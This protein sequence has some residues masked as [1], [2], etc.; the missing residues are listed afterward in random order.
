MS[1]DASITLSRN[2]KAGGLVAASVLLSSFFPAVVAFS[3][4]ESPFLFAFVWQIGLVLGQVVFLAGSYSDLLRSR[5]AW[6]R[7]SQHIPSIAMVVWIASQ[8]HI[9]LFVWSASVVDV[10]I[11]TVLY[12]TWPLGMA[13][14]TARL[15]RSESRYQRIGPL[16]AL[17]F[18]VAVAGVGLVALSHAGDVDLTRVVQ[19][20]ADAPLALAGGVGL[21]L[22]A[23][24]VNSLGSFGFR[25]GADLAE[26]LPQDGKHDAY[27]LEVFGVVVGSVILSLFA[28]PSIAL[29]GFARD[30]PVAPGSLW[31]AL[32]GGPLI[33]AGATILWRWGILMT[34]DLKIQV[35]SYVRPLLS[36]AW[37]YSLSLV[38]DI[39][40]GMLFGGAIV[41]VV[42]N[43]IVWA[44]GRQRGESSDS[45]PALPKELKDV[46]ELV[47]GGESVHHRGRTRS[48]SPRESDRHP[49]GKPGRAQFPGKHTRRKCP[50]SG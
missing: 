5:A 10:S 42:A 31:L 16:T 47:A 14:L 9:A 21:A 27:S 7:V 3:N 15:F 18:L 8:F 48:R 2:T 40:G 20:I 37:L 44:E 13:L 45:T 1:R 33:G 29:I 25:W 30:E 11:T 17:A 38:G 49:G 12:E 34:T 28:G 6:Q 32:V 26:D 50:R 41:I 23:A 43:L 39:D 35:V 46:H 22:G 36:L 19:Y 24:V 4:T